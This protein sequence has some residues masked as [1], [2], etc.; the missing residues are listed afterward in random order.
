M[1]SNLSINQKFG[2]EEEKYRD[3]EK[4][5]N[6]GSVF[7]QSLTKIQPNKFVGAGAN[8]V[9]TKTKIKKY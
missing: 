9:L 1:G 3:K 7:R 5:R 8:S 4:E 6:R 2:S